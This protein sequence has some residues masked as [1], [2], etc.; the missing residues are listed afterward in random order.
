MQV[1]VKTLTG[2]TITLEV[3]SYDSIDNLK[4]KIQDKEGIPPDQQRIIFAG[5]QLE[6]EYSIGDY[7]IPK[8]AT[9]HLVLRLRRGGPPQTEF[10]LEGN[11][12]FACE[13]YFDPKKNTYQ[14]FKKDIIIKAKLKNNLGLYILIDDHDYSFFRDEIRYVRRIDIFYGDIKNIVKSQKINGA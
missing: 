4:A 8:E 10:Y 2:K 12:I 3:S 6:N 1:Y 11:R 14:D 7:K 5:E 9:M 13:Y